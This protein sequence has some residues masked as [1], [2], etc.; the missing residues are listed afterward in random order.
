MGLIVVVQTTKQAMETHFGFDENAEHIG[1]FFEP[2]NENKTAAGNLV[3]CLFY[4]ENRPACRGIL[5]R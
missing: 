5:V 3:M 2:D 4:E 1:N